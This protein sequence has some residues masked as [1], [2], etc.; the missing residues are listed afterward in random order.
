[1]TLS[2]NRQALFALLLIVLDAGYFYQ[3]LSLPRPFQLGEPGPA[4]LPMILSA[5]L[6]IACARIL[7]KELTG[8]A[9]AEEEADGAGE[10]ITPRA[11]A[12]IGA[13]GGYIWLFEPLGYWP[14]TLLYTFAVAALFEHERTGSLPRALA[15]AAL[16][17]AGITVAG[18]LFFVS[19]FELFLPAGDF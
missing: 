2:M 17:A 6:L 15:I 5:I 8:T 16:I 14:A 18:W 4:F 13:T 11:I 10:R 19:L 9:E 1:M 7:W 3:S 12:L